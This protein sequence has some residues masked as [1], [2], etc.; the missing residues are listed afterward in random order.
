[1]LPPSWCCLHKASHSCDRTGECTGHAFSRIANLTS[2]FLPCLISWLISENS[3][4]GSFLAEMGKNGTKF[5]GVDFFFFFWKTNDN[6]LSIRKNSLQKI[7]GNLLFEKKKPLKTSFN[8]VFY[9]ISGFNCT[10]IS[11]E[12]ISH[13][14]TFNT[15]VN[16]RYD[17]FYSN[18]RIIDSHKIF[19]H[20]ELN[21]NSCCSSSLLRYTLC[22]SYRVIITKTQ[23]EQCFFNSCPYILRYVY[24][25]YYA[26]K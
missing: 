11:T 7:H 26:N 23:M 21:I 22:F 3:F 20:H 13:P 1:M 9:H 18:K 17:N 16:R 12:R 25:P 14:H 15:C 8:E 5:C 24:L 6:Y 2:R 4:S 10:L 19:A